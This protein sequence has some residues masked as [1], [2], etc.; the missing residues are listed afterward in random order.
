[1][2]IST[3][4][5]DLGQT[6]DSETR[7]NAK[8]SVCV[9]TP[10][11]PVSTELSRYVHGTPERSRQEIDNGP[12]ESLLAT[13]NGGEGIHMTLSL[14]DSSE[15]FHEYSDPGAMELVPLEELTTTLTNTKKSSSRKN[16]KKKNFSDNR[17]D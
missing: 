17:Y 14:Q 8:S 16:N 12:E 6:T 4:V 15:V 7:V 13:L 9:Y 3:D 1:M 11:A 10:A 5:T 2:R